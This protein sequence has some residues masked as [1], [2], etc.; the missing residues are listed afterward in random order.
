M[1]NNNKTEGASATSYANHISQLQK[2]YEQALEATGFAG[3]V[4]HSGRGLRQRAVDDQYWP[5]KVNPSFSQ[6]VPLQ[7]ADTIVVVQK[8]KKPTLIRPL[9]DNFWEGPAPEPRDFFT[10]AFDLVQ[11]PPDAIAKAL[12]AKKLAWIGDASEAAAELEIDPESVNPA[13]LVEK[14]DALRVI[15]SQ[16]EI[17][18]LAEASQIAARGHARLAELFAIGLYSELDLHLEYLR[19][20]QQNALETPYSNI[21]AQ[22]ANAAVLHHVHYTKHVDARKDLSLLVDAGAL[23]MGYASDITRTYVRG[24]SEA[25]KDFAALI[26]GMESLQLELCARVKPGMNYEDLHNHAHDRLADL[27]LACG[28][29]TGASASSLVEQGITR[30]FFPHGLGHSLGLQVH[31][32]GCRLVP[33]TDQNPFLRNTTSI[34]AGQVFTVEPGC[35]FIEGLLGP[36]KAT[37]ASKHV[38]WSAVDAL[39]PFGG[40]RIEDNLAVTEGA[41]INLTRDNWP[42]Q[43]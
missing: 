10:E 39:R 20:T 22:G 16:Y 3:V 38:S 28:I 27:L 13:S 37:G 43:P 32:V 21:V 42:T 24:Q 41:S 7:S 5:L 36:L 8:G 12:P 25:A 4:L 34:E 2:N 40:I 14:L 11:C 31:D 15:K 26:A 9:D 1:S 30:A 18:C 33:P 19:V 6:W 23:S 35:Y 29:A 17:Q